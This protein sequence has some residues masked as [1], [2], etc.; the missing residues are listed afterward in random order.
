MTFSLT[1]LDQRAKKKPKKEAF[2]LKLLSAKQHEK[3]V[4]KRNA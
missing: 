2:W 4:F 1:D 3:H